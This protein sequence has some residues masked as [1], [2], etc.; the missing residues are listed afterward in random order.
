MT[1]IRNY[2][3]IKAG[4][5]KTATFGDFCFDSLCYHVT[6]SQ[7]HF[8]RCVFFH[9]TF[10]F[11][12]QEVTAFT[13]YG[14]GHQD[15]ALTKTG[16]M[17]LYHFRVFQSTTGAEASSH[18]ITC[19][20]VRIGRTRPEHTTCTTGCNNYSRS[21]DFFYATFLHVPSNYTAYTTV[22]GFNDV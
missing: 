1:N 7:F 12:V 9:E 13:A 5:A 14:F 19:R 17:E 10:A 18:A 15:T 6:R 11:I 3:C 20:K 21:S 16:R 8:A 2:I 4:T 22:I